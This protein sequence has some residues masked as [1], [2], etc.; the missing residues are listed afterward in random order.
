MSNEHMDA[1]LKAL[2]LEYGC[3]PVEVCKKFP[4]NVCDRVASELDIVRTWVMY[5]YGDI[6]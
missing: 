1:E 6:D 5:W 2:I 4:L 3:P